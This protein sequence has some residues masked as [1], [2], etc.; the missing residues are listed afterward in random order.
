MNSKGRNSRDDSSLERGIS[1]RQDRCISNSL[2]RSAD[3]N[4]QLGQLA[5]QQDRTA[6]AN[7]QLAEQLCGELHRAIEA[8]SA[9]WATA[10]AQ[11]N[12]RSSLADRQGLGR[13]RQLIQA[14]AQMVQPIADLQRELDSPSAAG[15]LPPAASITATPSAAAPDPDSMLAVCDMPGADPVSIGPGHLRVR[16]WALSKAGIEDVS[17]FVDGLPR[18]GSLTALALRRRGGAS[19][20]PQCPPLRLRRQDRPR[21]A[22]GR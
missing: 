17:V 15:D 12:E 11:Q 10:L 16:G 21:G 3:I 1:P 6:A 14:M 2:R 5:E 18:E 4:L 13:H 19:R 9:T 20:V 7:R 8:N 22:G